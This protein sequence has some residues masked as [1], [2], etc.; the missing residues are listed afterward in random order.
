MKNLLARQLEHTPIAVTGLGAFSAAGTTANDLFERAVEGVPLSSI[1]ERHGVSMVACAAPWTD[2]LPPE[3]RMARHM[4][5]CA[6]MSLSAT[7]E[8]WLAAGL[9]ETD[10]AA[11]RIGVF[12][13]SSRGPVQ[14]CAAANDPSGPANPKPSLAANTTFACISGVVANFLG[15]RGPAVTVSA[16]C[17]SSAHAIILAA[18]QILLGTIDVAIAGGCEAPLI[19]SIYSQLRSAG[20]LGSHPDPRKVCRPFSASRNGLVLGEAAAFLI[21]E[22][23]HVARRRGVRSL[24]RLSGWGA[25]SDEVLRAGMSESSGNLHRNMI[26]ALELAGI[27]PDKIGYVHTHGTGTELN[28]RMEAQALMQTFPHGVPCSSTK[29]ITGHCMGASA[30]LG[31]VI[32]L[33]SME[34]GLLPPSVNCQPQDPGFDLDLIHSSSRPSH[35]SA[36]M[37][38]SSG[39]WGTNAQL[40]FSAV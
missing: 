7:R 35:P 30:A 33:K 29:P 37:V 36:L 34:C 22:S 39:F 12:V 20:V 4:D 28:D 11:D 16:T 2:R 24:A 19:P 25:G 5:H 31:T 6:R 13:G 17:A 18:Q 1:H 8:A 14:L 27:S 9:G 38:S 15:A 21:L 32:A 40:V 3:F 23:S 10:I 26:D